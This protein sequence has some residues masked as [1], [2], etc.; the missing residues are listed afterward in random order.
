MQN[1]DTLARISA[2]CRRFN[3]PAARFGREAVGDPSLVRDL[4]NGRVIG[5]R[6]KSRIN[7]YIGQLGGAPGTQPAQEQAEPPLRA[8]IVYSAA[9]DGCTAMRVLDDGAMPHVRAGD[10]VV[11]DP[12][13]RSPIDGELFVIEWSNGNRQV[14]ETRSRILRVRPCGSTAFIDAE[15]WFAEVQAVSR[16]L[17]ASNPR[18]E[19]WFDGPYTEASLTSKMIGRVVGLLEP[20]NS[21]AVAPRE[22][23]ELPLEPSLYQHIRM[24]REGSE[25]LL[26]AINTARGEC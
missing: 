16:R 4:R 26:Q 14:V 22:L 2:A 19:R 6:T 24:M 25:R 12:V 1:F 5:D 11:I 23:L 17:D 15:R 9:P 13:Q 10:V 3:I 18:S 20:G 7:A 8:F 21:F